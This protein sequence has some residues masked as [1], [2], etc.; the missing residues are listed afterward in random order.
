MAI[1]RPCGAICPTYRLQT[2]PPYSAKGV[3]TVTEDEREKEFNRKV[4]RFDRALCS[5]LINIAVSMLTTLFVLR[6]MRII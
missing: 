6:A 5:K 4:K 2:P 1:G 3:I